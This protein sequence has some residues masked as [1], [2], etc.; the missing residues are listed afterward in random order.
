MLRHTFLTSRFYYIAGLIVVLFAISHILPFVFYIGLG[1]FALFI[2]ALIFDFFSLKKQS[3]SIQFKRTVADKLSLGDNQTIKY[4]IVNQNDSILNYELVDEFPTQLQIRD[5][6]GIGEL[7]NNDEITFD[8]PI[9][10]VERGEYY[11]GK[12]HLFLSTNWLQLLQH[13]L[14]FDQNKMV[15]VIPSIIQM[16]HHQLQVFSKTATRQGIRKIRSIGE[17]DEFESLRPYT[18]GDNF[19]SINWKATARARKL[20]ANQYQNTRSQEVYCIID[21]GR[22]MKMPFNNLTLL[23]YAI[24]A[25][26]VL[27]NIILRKYDKSGLITFSTKIGALIKAQDKRG[28]LE[29]ISEALYG[30]KTDFK[31]SSF[32]LLYHTLRSYLKRRSII[33]LFSNFENMI[34]LNRNIRFITMMAKKH[35]LV[36]IFFKNRELETV[37]E[38]DCDSKSEIYLKT[39]AQ[40][41]ILEKEQMKL[42][43]MSMGVQTIMTHPEKL[44]INVIN[45][46]LEI[47]ARRLN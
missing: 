30:Q 46:Y 25:S 10:P 4:T 20:I 23:D 16:K 6:I 15:M 5:A 7:K 22:S 8:Y 12:S 17:N 28:Q 31:D 27:S 47:K 40:N 43:L 24:N 18:H 37:A 44:N 35:L 26:L 2:L 14:S 36:V 38:M 45:K 13:K 21:K 11:F 19:K 29:R 33:L 32:E 42:K 9:R 3:G 39:L 41:S 34:D 1:L